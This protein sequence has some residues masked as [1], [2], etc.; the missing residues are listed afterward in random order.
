[1]ARRNA[2]NAAVNERLF[3]DTVFVQ[4]L[5]NPLDQYHSLVLKYADRTSR[6]REIWITEA[7][8]FE[9]ANALSGIDRIR[10]DGFI[11]AAIARPTQRWCRSIPPSSTADW[12]CTETAQTRIGA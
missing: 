7:V 9:V 2:P 3:V 11:R 10:A 8:L 1:M 12:T 4:A 5:L 6:A